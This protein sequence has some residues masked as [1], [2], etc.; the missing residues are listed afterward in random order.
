MVYKK[1]CVD[2]AMQLGHENYFKYTNCAQA[3]FTA[4]VDAL[5]EQKV[6]LTSLEAE[7][8][9]FNALAGVSG[10]HANLGCGNCGALTG[11]AA[12]I[13]LA[14]NVDRSMQTLDKNFRWIAFDNVSKTI[15]EKFKKEFYGL[16]CRLVTWERYGKIWNLWNEESNKDF[17][18]EQI[19]R[20]Y[21]EVGKSTVSY[22]AGWGAEFVIDVLENP[23]TLEKVKSDRDL[24]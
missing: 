19:E 15:G 6:D 7:E 13:S 9:I 8:A 2:R 17:L 10:G 21:L 11:A 16:T 5:K 18:K 20:K 12:A 22:V 1:K 23:R 24:N 3:T 14:S 4:I